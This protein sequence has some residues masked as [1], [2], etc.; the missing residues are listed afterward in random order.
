[1]GSCYLCGKDSEIIP[2]SSGVHAYIRC[3]NCGRY[4]ITFQALFELKE[5][6]KPL[7][8]SVVFYNY[9]FLH[10]EIMLTRENISTEIEK[11]NKIT[12]QQKLYQL[13]R[14]IFKETRENGIGVKI[15]YITSSCC[16]A[17]SNDELLALMNTLKAKNVIAFELHSN[18][19]CVV[20][21][22]PIMG[23]EAYSKFEESIDSFDSFK[24]LI[25]SEKANVKIINNS[26]NISLGSNNT[27]SIESTRGITE[28]ELIKSMLSSNVDISII[29]KMR[30]EIKELIEE[31]NKDVPNKQRTEVILKKMF[32]IG[33][34][35]I[36]N[37]LMLLSK[38]EVIQVIDNIKHLL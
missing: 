11:V 26:G 29:D 35:I 1:M 19:P 17:K 22:N 33:G 25:M 6:N 12:T 7:L 18:G 8:S 23:I 9:Y 13:S 31:Y 15:P 28:T 27:Q 4:R 20:F 34:N 37:S 5:I 21:E 32:Q 2:G 3:K 24:E 10:N 38:P 30:P 16:Y 36:G 14:F